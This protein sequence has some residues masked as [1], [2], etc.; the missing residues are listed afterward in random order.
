MKYII[1]AFSVL[2]LSSAA[3]AE[4]PARLIEGCKELVRIY[5][6]HGERQAMVGFTTSVSD[7]M[8]AGYCRGVIDE[9]RRADR[10]ALCRHQEWRSQALKIARTDE[11]TPRLTVSKL[12]EGSCGG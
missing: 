7:A 3:S 9:F 11:K 10:S 8:R 5:D 2:A 12:L 1:A 4:D 6:K